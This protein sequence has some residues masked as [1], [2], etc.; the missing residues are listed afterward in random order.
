MNGII[1]VIKR[2][3]KNKGSRVMP[4]NYRPITLLCCSSKQFTAILNNRLNDY[5]EENYILTE[6]QTAFRHGYSTTDH[7]FNIHSLIEILKRKKN[8]LFCA[9]IEFQKEFHMIS[10]SFL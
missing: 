1:G 8:T 5:I 2:I 6:A 3:C 7:L 10:I 4:E 9:F